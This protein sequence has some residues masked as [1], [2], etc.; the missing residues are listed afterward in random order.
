MN[1]FLIEN[2]KERQFPQMVLTDVISKEHQVLVFCSGL[3]VLTAFTSTRNEL[4]NFQTQ[5]YILI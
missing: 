2:A 5:V 1:V 3:L 4:E